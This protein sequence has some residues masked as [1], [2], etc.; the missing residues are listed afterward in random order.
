MPV[1]VCTCRPVRRYGLGLT[2]EPPW[3][4][5]L[6]QRLALTS[7][8]QPNS[9]QTPTPTKDCWHAMKA[10]MYQRALLL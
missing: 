2:L 1:L 5:L 8:V 9:A 4:V 7:R 6:D 3:A 10:G